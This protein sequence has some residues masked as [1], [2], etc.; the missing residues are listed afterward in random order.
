MGKVSETMDPCFVGRNTAVMQ[1]TQFA[2]SD[3]STR[4]RII[5]TAAPKPVRS[6]EE[7]AKMNLAPMNMRG[8]ADLQKAPLILMNVMPELAISG[9]LLT[10]TA[11]APFGCE[12]LKIK[13]GEEK[14][15][16]SGRLGIPKFP[17]GTGSDEQGPSSSGKNQNRDDKE[18]ENHRRSEEPMQQDPGKQEKM[19]IR[20]RQVGY[21][22]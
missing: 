8:K 3:E 11:L 4:R 12:E 1:H 19:T 20:R 17:G 7:W 18:G 13:H 9:K 5:I 14:D 22:A 15:K 16:S 10:G 6:E 21:L 2:Y